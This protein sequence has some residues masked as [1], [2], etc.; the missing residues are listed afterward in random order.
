MSQKKLIWLRPSFFEFVS[1]IQKCPP[2]LHTKFTSF[3]DRVPAEKNFKTKCK[4]STA[5]AYTR[6]LRR[7]WEA[8]CLKVDT[9]LMCLLVDC[10]YPTVDRTLASL[11]RP[12]KKLDLEHFCLSSSAFVCVSITICV[13]FEYF[14]RGLSLLL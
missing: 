14:N 9:G 3:K 10:F 6:S 1:V 7:Q 12:R 8:L 4:H 2:S 5:K 11:H 13:C